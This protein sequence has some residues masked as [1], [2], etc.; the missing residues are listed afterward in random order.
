MYLF[1]IELK[2]FNLCQC[3]VVKNVEE[4]IKILHLSLM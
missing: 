3:E 4:S 1:F 2:V